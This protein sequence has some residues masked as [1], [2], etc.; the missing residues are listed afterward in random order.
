[1]SS[2]AWNDRTNMLAAVADGRF[3]VWY[4]PVVAFTDKDLLEQTVVRQEGRY[5]YIHGHQCLVSAPDPF[6]APQV[7][8]HS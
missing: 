4:D 3:T 7:H 1:M 5:M 8:K 2:I 6:H